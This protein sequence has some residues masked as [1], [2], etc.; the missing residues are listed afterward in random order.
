MS[1]FDPSH[2]T[3]PDVAPDASFSTHF[4]NELVELAKENKELCAITAA[5]KYGTD[6]Y[7]RQ[8]LSKCKVSAQNI[9]VVEVK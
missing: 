9:T 7:K 6:V 2:L 5:M 1:S 8:V 3:D 4:G